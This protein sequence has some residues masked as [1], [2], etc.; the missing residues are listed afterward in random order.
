MFSYSTPACVF[1]DAIL[2]RF[3]HRLWTAQHRARKK[4]QVCAATKSALQHIRTVT[5][6]FGM[7]TI[8]GIAIAV[9]PRGSRCRL[10]A[11]MSARLRLRRLSR[12][13]ARHPGRHRAR[14]PG[15]PRAR[16]GRPRARLQRRLRARRRSRLA[17]SGRNSSRVRARIRFVA[18]NSDIFER[19]RTDRRA[20]CQSASVPLGGTGADCPPNRSQAPNGAGSSS[21]VLPAT[22]P[23]R[24]S[25]VDSQ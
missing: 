10:P 12:P 6:A 11:A 1:F 13:R 19:S 9:A 7:H 3:A 15:R 8:A 2:E 25:D 17:A 23:A 5:V 20:D 4:S 22:A 18:T 16:P 14:H 21:G 24:K